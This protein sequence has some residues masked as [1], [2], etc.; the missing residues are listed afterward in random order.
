MN[1]EGEEKLFLII[2][3]N[4]PMDKKFFDI[5]MKYIKD[6]YFK[7]KDIEIIVK[8][9]TTN[10]YVNINSIFNQVKPD[11][12]PNHKIDIIYIYDSIDLNGKD[13]GN[14]KQWIKDIKSLKKL[15][16]V[17]VNTL[18]IDDCLEKWILNDSDS[19]GRYF[20]TEEV[21]D[22]EFEQTN[23]R[24]KLSRLFKKN[25][26]VYIEKNYIELLEFID[27]SKI[28]KEINAEIKKL[29]K[30]IEPYSNRN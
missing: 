1:K 9:I 11:R 8:R 18:K 28:F 6:D 14:I 4:N 2:F 5:L 10:K 27:I 25:N 7:I 30:I 19:I 12:S 24:D 20:K 15:P 22:M 29:L 17:K 21:L 23:S 13:G 26:K 16:N 3:V